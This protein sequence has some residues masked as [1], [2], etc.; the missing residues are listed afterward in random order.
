[1]NYL[2]YLNI[3][4]S[5][6]NF[7]CSFSVGNGLSMCVLSNTMAAK[8]VGLYNLFYRSTIPCKT[9]VPLRPAC[10]QKED[11]NFLTDGE[12]KGMRLLFHLKRLCEGANLNCAFSTQSPH[13]SAFLLSSGTIHQMYPGNNCLQISQKCSTYQCVSQKIQTQDA[14]DSF[15][16]R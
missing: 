9:L 1:M 4:Q 12:S 16:T 8:R 14:I 7:V 5:F 13:H 3:N 10:S 15:Y 6:Q 11:K 2:N